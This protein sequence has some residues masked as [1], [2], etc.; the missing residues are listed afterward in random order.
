MHIEIPCHREKV[1]LNFTDEISPRV[2]TI[3]TANHNAEGYQRQ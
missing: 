1:T 3:A 2:K